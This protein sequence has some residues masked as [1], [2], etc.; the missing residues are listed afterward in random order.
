MGAGNEQRSRWRG[1]TGAPCWTGKS[2]TF[3]IGR[4]ADVTDSIA[5]RRRVPSSV[6]TP[7]RPCA[8]LD[9]PCAYINYGPVAFSATGSSVDDTRQDCRSPLG[10]RWMAVGV[11]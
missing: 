10:D 7:Y 5:H 8:L 11:Q 2:R 6:A 9:A 3:S 1:M 4:T